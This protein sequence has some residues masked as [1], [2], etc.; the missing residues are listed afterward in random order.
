M[1]LVTC[2]QFKTSQEEQDSRL[3]DLENKTLSAESEL[4][5]KKEGE[6]GAGTITVEKIKEAIGGDVAIAVKPKSGIT[7]DGTKDNPLDL[8][9][10]ETLEVDDTG[11]LGIKTEK[12]AEEIGEYIAGNAL[13]FNDKTKQLDVTVF[14]LMDASGTHHLSNVVA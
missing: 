1:A 13:T 8:N 3:D 14:R 7:G 5:D 12:A 10:G 6:S 9:L 11:K 4:V 2:N